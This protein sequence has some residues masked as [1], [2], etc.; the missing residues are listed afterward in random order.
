MDANTV[1]ATKNAIIFNEK[2]NSVCRCRPEIRYLPLTVGPRRFDIT[3][4]SAPRSA[5][6]VVIVAPIMKLLV[7]KENLG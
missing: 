6:H 4:S 1:S 2:P 3:L 5:L 7:C